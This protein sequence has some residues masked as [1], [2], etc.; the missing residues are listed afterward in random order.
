VSVSV[1]PPVPFLVQ[2]HEGQKHFERVEQR[3]Q[4]FVCDRD[5][6]ASRSD[7]STTRSR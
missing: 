4:L 3:V 1:R 7:C 5:E 6:G 2:V